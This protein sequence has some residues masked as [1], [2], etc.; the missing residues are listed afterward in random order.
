M[1]FPLPFSHFFLILHCLMVPTGK[2]KDTF[3]ENRNIYGL[4]NLQISTFPYIP[5]ARRLSLT[6]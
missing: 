2:E 3:K 4:M 6:Y 1:T 5:H